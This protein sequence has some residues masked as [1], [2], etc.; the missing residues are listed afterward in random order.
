MDSSAKPRRTWHLLPR[1][2]PDALQALGDLPPVV[3]Q[4]LYNRGFRTSEEARAFL[5]PRTSAVRD[6]FQLPNAEPAVE[7][8]AAALRRQESIAI[9]GDFDADGVTSSALLTEGLRA[10][11]ARPIPYIPDR[12][13]EGHG[14]NLPALHFL[15]QQGVRL[16]LTADCGI[17]SVAEVAAAAELGMDIVITDHHTPPERV[18]DAVAV[19][20]PKLEGSSSPYADLAAVG[21]A[22]KLVEAL[23]AK[24]GQP[25]D[26][27]LLEYVALG[28]VA[29]VSPMR[30]ENRYLVSR[31]LDHLNRSERPGIRELIKVSGLA[32]GQ[33]DTE[34]ISYALGPCINA[35]GRMDRADPSYQL[36][37]AR[38]A[39]EAEPLAA[40]LNARN[41]ERRRLTQET[42]SAIEEGLE[43]SLER[44]PPIL[45]LGEPDFHPGI[46]GLAAG[47]LT[48]QYHRPAIVCQVG[49][50]ETR[51]S[52]RSIP[53]F[54]IIEALG[55]CD[56]LFKRY[57]GHAQAAGFTIATRD[58]PE[59]RER[60]TAIASAALDGL[61]LSPRI[62]ID[63]EM[64]LGQLDGQIIRALRG[65]APHGPGNP[66]PTFLSRGV[67][68]QE[69]RPMGEKGQH[70][71]L[72]LKGG[73]ATWSA[74]AFDMAMGDGPPPPSIDVVF[75][76]SIDRWSGEEL[77]QL[78]VLDMAPSSA[79][80]RLL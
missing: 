48:E 74:V 29:D 24:L 55:R 33:V 63:A 71:R 2:E 75:T 49:P 78:R 9:F 41:Q 58:L 65:L 59:L 62:A 68:V 14:L 7:R 47:K 43:S 64:P 76:L 10:L 79:A 60:L 61:A 80:P 42:L 77:L 37:V 34:A 16:V 17:T 45:I 35:P 36:L 27:S 73:R 22:F 72:K 69:I 3:A 23:S 25:A 44:V 20:D 30:G 6:A 12:V 40:E 11:G 50:E 31:G 46:I 54:N 18:P 19:V 13:S 15:H 26:E 39:A 66:P 8:L 38:S 5:E 1:A 57:G 51:G 53:E 21:V 28:T 52:C 56:D 4:L 67:Q 32:P 70:S